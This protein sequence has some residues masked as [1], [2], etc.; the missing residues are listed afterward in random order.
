MTI[1]HPHYPVQGVGFTRALAAG[2]TGIV[3]PMSIAW[4]AR[5]PL[6]IEVILSLGFPQPNHASV[7]GLA[8]AAIKFQMGELYEAPPVH[9]PADGL[10]MR[11]TARRV[12]LVLHVDQALIATGGVVVKG[13]I[14]PCE[15]VT[16]PLP[17][18]HVGLYRMSYVG[19]LPQNPIPLAARDIR[20]RPSEASM[21]LQPLVTSLRFYAPDRTTIVQTLDLG[22]L[23]DWVTIPFD[24]AWWD[25]FVEE[26][27]DTPFEGVVMNVGYR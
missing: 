8:W 4:E 21:W 1:A 19:P 6:P 25:L 20:I 13:S 5:V 12:E 23:L 11:V 2:L 17:L 15:A 16:L 24:A 26:D 27:D 9:V 18:P 14:A 3:S 10:R 7:A 22:D